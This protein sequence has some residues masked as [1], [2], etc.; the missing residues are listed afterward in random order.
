MNPNRRVGKM[1][2]RSGVCVRGTLRA[3]VAQIEYSHPRKD[4]ADWRFLF[5]NR[6]LESMYFETN[7]SISFC[8][9]D[10]NVAD[11]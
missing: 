1:N 11:M 7:L 2:R 8:I 5:P 4:T 10:F 3:F 6:R 9:R